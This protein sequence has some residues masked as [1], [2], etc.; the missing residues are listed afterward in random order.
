MTLEDE[1]LDELLRDV[2]VPRDLKASLLKI[3]G[4]EVEVVAAKPESKSWATLIGTIAAIAASVVLYFSI[5]PEPA[6]FGVSL[7]T[8][9]SEIA[10]LI[11]EMEQNNQSINS[12]LEMQDSG[13]SREISTDPIFDSKESIASALSLS[14][15]VAVDQGASLD[16]VRSELQYVVD[17]YPDTAG[18]QRARGLLQIN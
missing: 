17:V 12:I 14:W 5:Q 4:R 16:S 9:E 10:M 2:D 8:N 3:P 1:K 7:A 18:A 15:Q 11:A 13:F 6:P